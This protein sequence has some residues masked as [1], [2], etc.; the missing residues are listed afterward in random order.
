MVNAQSVLHITLIT[1]ILWPA[2][3]DD[4]RINKEIR[5][6]VWVGACDLP[7][8]QTTDCACEKI[9]AT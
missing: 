8:M 7:T 3:D 2:N 9:T 1:A 5:F 6:W 4:D